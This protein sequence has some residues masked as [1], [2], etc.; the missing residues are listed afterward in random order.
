MGKFMDW[1]RNISALELTVW[2]IAI[3][4]VCA[5]LFTYYNR[6]ILGGFVRTLISKEALSIDSAITLAEAGYQKNAFIRRALLKRDTF[7]KIVF[8]VD[9]EIMVASEGHS[10]SARTKPINLNTARFYVA[11]E[12]KIMAELRYDNKGADIFGIITSI[13]VVLALAYVVT[14]A[15]PHLVGA[16]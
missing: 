12:N 9:D 15:V 4:S 11:Q 8:E 16:F 10:F 2:S 13:I 5:I 7:R 6:T 1:L 14:L 3:G